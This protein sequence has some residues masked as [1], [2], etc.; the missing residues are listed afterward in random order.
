MSVVAVDFGKAQRE[1]ARRLARLL[2]LL[3]DR[4]AEMI[5]D[6]VKFFEMASD[7]IVELEYF[8][9]S[10]EEVYAEATSLDPVAAVST[11]PPTMNDIRTIVIDRRE[12]DALK[13]IE[14]M[15]RDR[16]GSIA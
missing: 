12:Y 1:A 3:E 16:P 5:A 15:L 4:D 2:K 10:L 13:L 6:P 9:R 8:I 14:H 7:K 11:E